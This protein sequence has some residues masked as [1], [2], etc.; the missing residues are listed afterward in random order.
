MIL[1]YACSMII[2]LRRLCERK[3][4]PGTKRW[5]TDT[6]LERLHQQKQSRHRAVP[7]FA[8]IVNIVILWPVVSLRAGRI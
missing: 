6:V 8:N 3:G 7:S 4:A 5:S 1:L 2:C